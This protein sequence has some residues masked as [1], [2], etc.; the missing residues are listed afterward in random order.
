M[1]NLQEK[2]VIFDLDGT[3][4]DI[5]HRLHHIKKE[6]Q[7]WDAFNADCIKDSPKYNI[8]WLGAMAKNYGIKIAIVTGREEVVR[9]KTIHWLNFYGISY[10]EIYMRKEGDRRSDVDVK[11]EVFHNHF[12]NRLVLF[13]IEDR[14]RVVN[15]WRSL[16]LTCLQCQPGDY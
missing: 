13:V 15:M 6:L 5:T 2:W 12:R 4:A 9:D 3:L 16:G 1:N 10:D 11:K 7:D 14:E 8:M